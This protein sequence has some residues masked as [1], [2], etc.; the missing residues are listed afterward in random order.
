MP[1]SMSTS[2]MTRI[3]RLE[4]RNTDPIVVDAFSPYSQS[5]PSGSAPNNA[6]STVFVISCI[7]PRFTSAVEEYLLGQLGASTRYDLFVLAGSAMGGVLTGNGAPIP[8]CSLVA[9]GNSWQEVLLDHLQVAISLH[10]VS[11]IYI[12]DHL[13]CAAYGVCGATDTAAGH[14][15]QFTDLRT[16]IA[17]STFYASGTANPTGKVPVFAS[18][19]I[20]G[21]YFNTPVGLTTELFNY[22]ATAPGTSVGTFTFPPTSGAKVLVLGCIDPRFSQIL[23]SFLTN[24]KEVQF[25]YDL[26][27]MA[28]SSLGVNQSYKLNGTQRSNNNTGDAY[29]NNLLA[30]T[31]IG[32][33]GELGYAWGPTFFDHLTVAVLVH[34]ITEVWVFD[35]LD[36]GAYKN[37]KLASG[38]VPA[39]TDNDPNQHIP[40]IQ[41]L[42]ASIKT[43]RPSLGFKGF[44]MDTAGVITKVVD[45][46]KGVELDVIT[47][48]VVGDFGSSRIRAPASEIIDLRAKASADYVLVR[49]HTGSPNS[50]FGRELVRT[51]LTPTPSITTVLETKVGPLKSALLN[52]NRL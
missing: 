14:R 44:I 7:D 45:D 11:K 1:M 29:P 35:H 41:K 49:E 22:T 51:K 47:Y 3:K 25:N 2:D 34:N 48:P 37:I 15:T 43:A 8:N 10:G 40:E 13:G 31:G 36:C 27:I 6:G 16:F 5:V 19:D 12:I 24:Y 42:Q 32:K 52:R 33:I 30:T 46:N 23:S 39:A 26:F 50:G 20:T 4:N 18:G 9:V 38:G 28:G 17:A 21:L